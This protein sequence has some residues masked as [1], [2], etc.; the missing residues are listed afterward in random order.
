MLLAQALAHT[1]VNH[2]KTNVEFGCGFGNATLPM[3]DIF[4]NSR[5]VAWDISPNLLAILER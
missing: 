2:A 1:G 5:I 4:P 3:L